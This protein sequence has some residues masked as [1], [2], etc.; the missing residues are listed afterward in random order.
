MGAEDWRNPAP[1]FISGAPGPRPSRPAPR[2]RLR[3]RQP[4]PARPRHRRA[5]M[6]ARR[7]G[8]CLPRGGGRVLTRPWWAGQLSLRAPGAS[9]CGSRGGRAGCT[10]ARFLSSQQACGRFSANLSPPRHSILWSPADP[11]APRPELV[12]QVRLCQPRPGGP[13]GAHTELETSF[14]SPK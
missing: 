5:P 8:G 14:P 2:A 3:T 6:G 4:R 11:T 12:P 1:G 13:Q 7:G 10:S 9:T